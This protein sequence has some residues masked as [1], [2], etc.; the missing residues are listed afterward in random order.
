[1][2]H[3]ESYKLSALM[4]AWTPLMVH[5]QLINRIKLDL[6]WMPPVIAALFVTLA[7]AIPLEIFRHNG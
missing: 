7:L 1:M 4:F 2:I 3:I 5:A 6:S